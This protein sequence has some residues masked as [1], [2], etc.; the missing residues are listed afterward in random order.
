MRKNQVQD[1]RY[2]DVA[3]KK[4]ILCYRVIIWKFLSHSNVNECDPVD[5]SMTLKVNL[6]LENI[7]K[8]NKLKCKMEKG[9][10]VN[11]VGSLIY[12]V[13]YKNNRYLLW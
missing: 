13:V 2:K 1:L 4:F 5:T 9:F 11:D 7:P 12:T 3:Q 8:P 6:S 10:H